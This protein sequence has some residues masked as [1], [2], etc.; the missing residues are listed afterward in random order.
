MSIRLYDEACDYVTNSRSHGCRFQPN[1][2]R[3]IQAR[4]IASEFKYV[5]IKKVVVVATK[6]CV[7]EQD[8]REA[9]TAVR[10]L[11]HYE[12]ESVDISSGKRKT[13]DN[14]NKVEKLLADVHA[15]CNWQTS[16]TRNSACILTCYVTLLQFVRFLENFS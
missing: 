10:T 12:S 6:L 2:C 4:K 8:I 13:S 1:K 5:S 3:K 9:E 14:S 16:Y 11:V 7:V 15:V